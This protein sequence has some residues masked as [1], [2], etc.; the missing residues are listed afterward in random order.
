MHGPRPFSLSTAVG[1]TQLVPAAAL[2][3]SPGF[4]SVVFSNCAA[5]CQPMWTEMDTQWWLGD[6]STLLQLMRGLSP[7]FTITHKGDTDALIYNCRVGASVFRGHVHR[8]GPMFLDHR[9]CFNS[10]VLNISLQQGREAYPMSWR[11]IPVT[12]PFC[13]LL[14]GRAA[15]ASGQNW[16]WTR[17]SHILDKINLSPKLTVSSILL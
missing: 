17:P 5:A 13:L 15:S 7:V 1:F 14:Q 6:V 16:S 3:V 9:L 4:K 11:S 10:V 8:H 2:H 12:L